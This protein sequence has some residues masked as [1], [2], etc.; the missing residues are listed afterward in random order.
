M[1]KFSALPVITLGEVFTSE[2]FF[3]IDVI[4]RYKYLIVLE[5]VLF[6]K[7]EMNFK[8][9]FCAEKENNVNYC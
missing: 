6:C 5:H 4:I 9:N 2:I 1:C 8:D 3:R 7:S